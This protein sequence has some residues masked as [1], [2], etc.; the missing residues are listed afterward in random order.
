[1]VTTPTVIAG[2][3]DAGGGRKQAITTLSS[4]H[5]GRLEDGR[6]VVVVERIVACFIRSIIGYALEAVYAVAFGRY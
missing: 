2:D 1:M 3:L 5:A 6:G 4:S